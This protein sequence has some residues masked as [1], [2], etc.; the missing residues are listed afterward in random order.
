MAKGLLLGL[1]KG[2]LIGG[3]LGALLH[4]GLHWTQLDPGS[5]INYLFF[6]VVAALAGAL[7]GKPPWKEGAG[8]ASALKGVFGLLL[9]AGVYALASRYVRVP[10]GGFLEI[11]AGTELAQAPL[12]FA[13]ALAAL[14]S[15]LVEVDDSFETPEEKKG[16]KG[17]RTGVRADAGD[18]ASAGDE[19]E[20]PAEAAKKDAKRKRA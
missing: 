14:Y 17:G 15:V 4:F 11:P 13:P 20:V 2:A 12:L 9:G 16:G 10:V 7:S 19:L 18:E 3:A 5:W 6:A 1:L 8:I